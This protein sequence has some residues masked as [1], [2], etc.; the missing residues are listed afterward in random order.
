MDPNVPPSDAEGSS[1]NLLFVCT[2]NTCR[3]PMA[4]TL[5]RRE[6]ERRGWTHVQVAS[7]GV[8]ADRG[9]PASDGALAV[10]RRRGLD[11][12]EH[13]SRPLTPE[14]VEWA[15]LVLA[16]SPSHLHAIADLG[17]EHKM[18]LLG[19]FADA[20]PGRGR[21][22]RD[23]FGGGEGEYEDTASQLEDLVARSL[24]RLVPILRP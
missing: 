1:Y 9:Y 20:S 15:D 18:A 10:M 16:M 23:P 11:L 3:S 5:A 2:G 8:A 6:I 21:L 19:D 17:G 24:D 14:L 13:G 22:V 7:A 12:R 4:E